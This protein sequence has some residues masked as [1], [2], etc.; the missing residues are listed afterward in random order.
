[1]SA[2]KHNIASLSER[3]ANLHDTYKADV[4]GVIEDAKKVE[5]EPAALRRLVSWKRIPSVKRAEREAIDDQYRF[6]AGELPTPATLPPDSELATA[7]RLFNDDMSVRQVAEE[8]EISVGKAHKL[9]THAAAFKESVHVQMNMN[10]PKAREMVA[11]DIGQWLPPHDPD[12]GEVIE[13]K[14]D[15][16]ASILP[17]PS[18]WA[19][20]TSVREAHHAAIE[21]AREAKREARRREMEQLNRLA[22][23][24]DA[25]MPE[26]LDFL[27]GPSPANRSLRP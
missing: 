5:V 18:A 14:A 8:M 12:T 7:V 15:A 21:A 19:S 20:I 3:L 6:L 22:A 11:D 17:S 13:A 2:N 4:E 25:D 23:I 9:K 24:T 27:Q 10:T 26:P 16:P 1:M